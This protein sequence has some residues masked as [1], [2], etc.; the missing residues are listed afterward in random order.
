MGDT[1][2]RDPWGV[3]VDRTRPLAA[4]RGVAIDATTAMRAHHIAASPAWSNGRRPDF[5]GDLEV[6]LIL[7]ATHRQTTL[8]MALALIRDLLGASRRPSRSAVHRYWQVLDRAAS[9]PSR[10]SLP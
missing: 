3:A 1:A 10:A 5:W 6:R 9:P 8:D 4:E 2:T 7:T